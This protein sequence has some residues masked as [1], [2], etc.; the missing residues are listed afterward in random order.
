MSPLLNSVASVL[1]LSLVAQ[2]HSRVPPGA[3]ARRWNRPSFSP[4]V[5]ALGI[6][7]GHA[8]PVKAGGALPRYRSRFGHRSPMP[9]DRTPLKTDPI[10]VEWPAFSC[11]RL[12]SVW[13]FGA[14]EKINYCS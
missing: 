2:A 14:A 4:D 13:H 12:T 6:V 9:E 10:W 7:G 8:A 5:G 3:P 1:P 11:S